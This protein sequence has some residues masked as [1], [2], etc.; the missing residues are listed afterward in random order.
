MLEKEIQILSYTRSFIQDGATTKNKAAS[1]LSFVSDILKAHKELELKF[2]YRELLTTLLKED[3][4]RSRKQLLKDVM[5]LVEPKLYHVYLLHQNDVVVY[6]GKSK[7]VNTRLRQH[8]DK[9][10]DKIKLC[11]VETEEE[12]DKLENHMIFELQPKHNKSVSLRWAKEFKE[13]PFEYEFFNTNELPFEFIP[14]LWFEK[15]GQLKVE[16]YVFSYPFYVKN[17]LCLIPKWMK[18]Y[19]TTKESNVLDNDH[20][21]VIK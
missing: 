9:T 7:N 16:D 13:S 20:N 11:Q 19:Q 18:E 5:K 10:H 6:V 2:V 21:C 14:C 12:V 8:E 15:G 1:C 4:H 3:F 17:E